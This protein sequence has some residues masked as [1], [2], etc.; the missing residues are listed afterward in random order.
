LA[1]DSG[2][3]EVFGPGPFA[4]VGVV[5]HSNHGL[6]DSLILRTEL[7]DQEISEVW[8]ALAE[9]PDNSPGGGR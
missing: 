3:D 1:R 2:W 4:V 5:D 8:L 9:W 7:G 6:A